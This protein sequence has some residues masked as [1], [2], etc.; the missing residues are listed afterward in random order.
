MAI[1]VDIEKNLKDFNLKSQFTSDKKRIGILG[2]SGSGKS[3]TLRSIAGLVSPTSGQIVLNNQVL[4]DAQQGINVPCQRRNIGFLFQNFA[5]FPHLTVA[6]NIRIGIRDLSKKEQQRRVKEKMAMIQLTGLEHRYPHQISGGQQQRVALARALA[7]EPIALL[8]DE[9]F[10]ALDNHLR[11]H[12]EEQL[13]EVLAGYQGITIFVTHNLEEAYRM[14]ED[15]LVMDQGR[16]VAAGDRKELFFKPPTLAA[17]QLM[18]YRNISRA[19]KINND[20]I[21]A[22]DWNCKVKVSHQIPEPL[23]YIGISS[24]GLRLVDR[25]DLENTFPG[26]ITRYEELPHQTKVYLSLG[27]RIE[28]ASKG[29]LELMLSKEEWSRLRSSPTECKVQID[30]KQFFLL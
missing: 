28:G 24:Y 23:T 10:S 21:E 5:L 13:L 27:T 3:M 12:M 7:K 16:V 1:T 2:A 20:T 18:G 6:E 15:L 14:A 22:L 9:P 17:A 25:G 4:F 30:T 19:T 29:P 11:K 8:L 26:L